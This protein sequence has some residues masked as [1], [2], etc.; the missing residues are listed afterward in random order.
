VTASSIR[1]EPRVPSTRSGQTTRW[2]P[3]RRG[4]GLAI[5]VTTAT[6]LPSRTAPASSGSHGQRRSSTRSTNTSITPP[7]VS[8]TAKASSSLTP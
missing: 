7:H 6:G 1:S 2:A 4:S 3:S 5:T 8:P